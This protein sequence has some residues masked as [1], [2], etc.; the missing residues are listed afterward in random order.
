MDEVLIFKTSS[1]NISGIEG[2]I[3]KCHIIPGSHKDDLQ[4]H[5]FEMK[6]PF[7]FLDPKPN[8]WGSHPCGNFYKIKSLIDC[9]TS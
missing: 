4:L 2:P 6:T 9:N 1:V 8:T 5:V 3:T 7:F